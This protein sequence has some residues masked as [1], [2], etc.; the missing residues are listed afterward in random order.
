AGLGDTDNDNDV[1][2]TDLNNVRNNFGAGQPVGSPVP[3]P[4]TAVLALGLGLGLAGWLRRK[5]A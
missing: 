2:I 4:S 5:K 3:E 1:D